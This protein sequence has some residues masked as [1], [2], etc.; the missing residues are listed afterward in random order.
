MIGTLDLVLVNGTGAI[1]EP[2]RCDLHVARGESVTVDCTLR[3][4]SGVLVDLVDKEIVYGVRKKATGTPAINRRLAPNL[5]AVGAARLVLDPADTA[6]LKI[7]TYP[8]SDF[9]LR[10]LVTGTVTPVS[11]LSSFVLRA[12]GA[13]LDATPTDATSSGALVQW[14]RFKVTFSDTDTATV[15]FDGFAFADDT[16][17]LQPGAPLVTSGPTVSVNATAKTASGFTLVASG[18]FTGEVWVDCIGVLA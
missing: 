16:Y 15:A 10:D 6:A 17:S 13:A 7:A 11:A 1:T 3:D 14:K 12:A 2:P 4:S 8:F 5:D 9:W 18:A